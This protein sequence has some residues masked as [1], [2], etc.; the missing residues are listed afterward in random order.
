MKLKKGL[1]PL[2]LLVVFVACKDEEK[3]EPTANNTTP[4]SLVASLPNQSMPVNAYPNIDISPMDMIYFPVEYPKLK[5][6]GNIIDT[7]I[8]KPV[9]RVIYSRPHL[10]KRHLFRDLLKY[11]E[12]WR[13]GAN[14][15]TEI[16][17]YKPVT[18]QGKKIKPG[19]YI[20]YA[21]PHPETWTIV[22]NS[23][24]DSWGLHPDPAKDVQRFDIPV[25]NTN[26][27][28]EYF[29]IVFE[30]AGADANLVISWDNLVARLPISI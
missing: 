12:P 18:I 4:D 16:E 15:S 1:L 17:F 24:T 26:P 27:V 10:G 23:N 25:T 30:N 19:R 7:P 2:L 20:L 28:Q 11:D 5:M 3:K 22:L 29:T 6:T 8:G 13:L 14:E 21:I 9:A